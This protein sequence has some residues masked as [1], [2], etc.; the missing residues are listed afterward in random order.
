MHTLDKL[1]CLWMK[2]YTSPLAV[3]RV[4]LSD[5]FLTSQEFWLQV[6]LWWCMSIHGQE[7]HQLGPPAAW[8][9]TH[10]S[11]ADKT[12]KLTF[13]W[14]LQIY[15]EALSPAA[16]PQAPEQL[17]V[18]LPAWSTQPTGSTWVQLNRLRTGV[19]YFM[20]SMHK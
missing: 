14:F 9:H 7:S 11:S 5:Y 17:W 4:L 16:S 20:A 19:G 2:Q 10:G 18:Y 1:M 6:P 12:K 8:H 3:S 13:R 15:V